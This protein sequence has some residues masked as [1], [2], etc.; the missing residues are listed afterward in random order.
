MTKHRESEP[1]HAGLRGLG[2]AGAIGAAL[3]LTACADEQTYLPGKREDVRAVLQNPGVQDPAFDAID[4]PVP[5]NTSRAIAL[6]G[7]VN[8]A[9][10]THSVG[11]PSTRVGHPAL[12]STLQPVWSAKIGAGDSRKQRITADPV[13]AGGRV[14][15]LDAGAQ[16]TAT[17]TSGQTLWTRDLTPASDREG[18]A[19]GGGLA[20]DGETLYVS[21][22]FGVLAAL[23]VTTG[24]VR[25]TQ[26]LDATG[27]GTPTVSG[28]LVYLTARDDTGWALDKATG[29]I[30]WQ[31]GAVTSLSNV[32]GAPAPAVTSDLAIFAF[33]SD[34][35]CGQPFGPSGRTGCQ[36]RRP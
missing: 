24:G 16:V 36:Q 21:V 35:L 11:T 31:T 22:G 4:G 33:G 14:F 9:N 3:L 19:T 23:D 2:V 30:Q 5:E 18:Q 25:W 7:A 1:G 10:W 28:D 13:V 26:D 29:R 6:G 17:S 20:V 15:T 27:S 8:N 12:R 32:L 34:C